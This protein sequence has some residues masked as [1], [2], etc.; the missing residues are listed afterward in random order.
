MAI[1]SSSLPF[2]KVGGSLGFDHPSYVTRKADQDL[3]TALMD[4]QFCYVFNC[5]QMGKSSLRVR[6][7]RSLEKQGMRCT[8]IDMTMLGSEI[9]PQQWY[10]GLITQLFQGFSLFGTINLKSWLQEKQGLSPVQQLSQFVTEIVL[11][12]T[13]DRPL[14]IFIDEID[15][16]LSLEFSV[17]DFFALI[18]FFYNQRAEDPTF[19]RITVALFGVATPSDL[20]QDKTQT[21]FNSI[22]S[23]RLGND[24]GSVYEMWQ[25]E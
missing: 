2:F 23:D 10:G 9:T 8:A 6:A 5:R 20:I 1:A 24:N 16:I 18:R 4:R 12:H 3:L 15:K 19:H 25:G 14:F 21:L 17:D 22:R 11:P 7:M 13:D